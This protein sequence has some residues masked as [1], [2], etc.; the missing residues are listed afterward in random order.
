[1]KKNKKSLKQ[2]LSKLKIKYIQ[3]KA[4]IPRIIW[5]LINILIVC[6]WA[7]GLMLVLD[8]FIKTGIGMI[9]FFQSMALYFIIE[10]V[11][12]WVNKLNIYR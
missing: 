4:R 5:F 8:L 1:M 2:I 6:L 10:Q 11:K 9:Q 3:L 12:P 7:I